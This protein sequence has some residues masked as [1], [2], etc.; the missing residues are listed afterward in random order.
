MHELR[1]FESPTLEMTHLCAIIDE[2]SGS[3]ADVDGQT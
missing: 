2:R 3:L 1:N